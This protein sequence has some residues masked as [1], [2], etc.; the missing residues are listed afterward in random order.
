MYPEKLKLRMKFFLQPKNLAKF[1]FPIVSPSTFFH[2]NLT[3]FLDFYLT[4]LWL[5]QEDKSNVVLNL[6]ATWDLLDL[7]QSISEMISGEA[8]LVRPLQKSINWRPMKN[9][10][11]KRRPNGNLSGS[12]LDFICFSWPNYLLMHIL[13]G[14]YNQ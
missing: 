9:C 13:I 2:S 1:K 10:S 11:G 8:K 4:F 14:D 3:K 5:G 12:I 6:N 7:R